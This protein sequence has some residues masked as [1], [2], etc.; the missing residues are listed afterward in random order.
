ML[1]LC[2]NFKIKTMKTIVDWLT[3]LPELLQSQALDN[4][5]NQDMGVKIAQLEVET[6]SGAIKVAFRWYTT[7]EGFDFWNNIYNSFLLQEGEQD[8]N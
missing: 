8:E 1:Y 2:R 4:L 6:M 3:D 5:F 7:P